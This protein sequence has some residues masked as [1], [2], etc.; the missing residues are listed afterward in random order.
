M[1]IAHVRLENG[2]P[3]LL[4]REGKVIAAQHTGAATPLLNQKEMSNALIVQRFLIDGFPI[5]LDPSL[6]VI[7]VSKM[8]RLRPRR[9]TNSPLRRRI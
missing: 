6:A 2:R 7:D 9:Q 5:F 4:D 3:I 1:E 8:A